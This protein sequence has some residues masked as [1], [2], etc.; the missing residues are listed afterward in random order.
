MFLFIDYKDY[1]GVCVCE[2]K[3][4]KYNYEKLMKGK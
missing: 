3:F 4:R 1:T 2:Y